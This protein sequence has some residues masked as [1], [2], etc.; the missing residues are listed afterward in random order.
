M[1][2]TALAR[3]GLREYA[4]RPLLRTVGIDRSFYAPIPD[5]DL[6]RYPG[7]LPDGFLACAKAGR[8]SPFGSASSACFRGSFCYRCRAENAA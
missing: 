2:Q 5:D 8:N 4:R 3:E 6:K 1:S 7:Q